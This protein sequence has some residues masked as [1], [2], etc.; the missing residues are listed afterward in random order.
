MLADVH[1][2]AMQALLTNYDALVREAKT[3]DA[4]LNPESAAEADGAAAEVNRAMRLLLDGLTAEARRS[5][6]RVGELPFPVVIP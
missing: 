6:A 5:L 3:S 2:G 1:I 4:E